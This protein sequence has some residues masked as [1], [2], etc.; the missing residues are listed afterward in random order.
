MRNDEA[1]PWGHEARLAQHSLQTIVERVAR[2][3][4]HLSPRRHQIVLNRRRPTHR[5]R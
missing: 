3:A 5:H 1:G 4:R 2:R